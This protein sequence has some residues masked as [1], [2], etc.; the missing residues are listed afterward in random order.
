MN[1]IIDACALIAYLKDE[2]GAEIV[3]LSLQSSFFVCFA[4]AI[5]LCEMYYG[6][7]RDYGE[8]TAQQ[9]VAR[10]RNAGLII[11]EDLDE[12]LWLVAGRI[13]ADYRRVSLA[14]CLCAALANRIG[15]EVVT[16]DRHEFE[17]LATS[18]VCR[19][20]FIR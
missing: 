14:D 8:Q 15:G 7:R 4:H 10:F 19:V 20:R 18:G 9:A 17:T 13:K 16:A 11:R 1:L 12:N 6:I 5:N 2:P 3:D